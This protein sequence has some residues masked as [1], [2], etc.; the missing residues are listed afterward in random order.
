MNSMGTSPAYHKYSVHENAMKNSAI[1]HNG[2]KKL[3]NRKRIFPTCWGTFVLPDWFSQVV[4][5]LNSELPGGVLIAK[6]EAD[7]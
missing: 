4:Q 6:W 7:E 1:Y 5:K 2:C 3:H